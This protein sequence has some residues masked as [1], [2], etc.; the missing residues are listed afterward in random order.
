MVHWGRVE[1]FPAPVSPIPADFQDF[2][3]DLPIAA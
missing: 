3:F 1:V 2:I